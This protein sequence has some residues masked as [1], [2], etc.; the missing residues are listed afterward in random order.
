MSVLITIELVMTVEK[1]SQSMKDI[2]ALLQTMQLDKFSFVN[3][4]YIA[5]KRKIHRGWIYENLR[6]ESSLSLTA[7][8]KNKPRYLSKLLLYNGSRRAEESGK[9]A[10]ECNAMW[11][12]CVYDHSY[13]SRCVS[14]FAF[15][16]GSE[17]KIVEDYF[18]VSSFAGGFGEECKECATPSAEPEN[19]KKYNALLIERNQH[20]C[21]NKHFVDKIKKLL[22]EEKTEWAFDGF[23]ISSSISSDTSLLTSMEDYIDFITNVDEDPANTSLCL[24]PVSKI[25]PPAKSPGAE[26]PF[27]LGKYLSTISPQKKE[28]P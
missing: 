19:L 10:F 9:D 28:S 5:R 22:E 25:K 4:K 6:A 21:T 12:V 7:T 1:E 8:S 23:G 20:Y 17:A 3:N 11:P 13:K 26:K 18:E 24:T 2:Y 15:K 16:C 27:H 14:Y